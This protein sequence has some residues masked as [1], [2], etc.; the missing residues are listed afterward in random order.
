MRTPLIA[1]AG[2]AFSG[3]APA[4]PAGADGPADLFEALSARCGEA[5][6][7]EVVSADPRDADMAGERLVMHVRD[8]GEDV[9]RIPFHVG[10]DRSRTWVLTRLEDGR[11]RLKHDHRH[12][13]GSPDVLTQYGGETETALDGMRADFPAD[14][15][16][17]DLFRREGLQASVQNV[18]T[19]QIA[20]GAF[21]YALNRPDRSFQARFD[22]AAPVD[23]P[24]P[25]WGADG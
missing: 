19:V 2:L 18:W 15:E 12:E 20:D 9:L 25:P 11:M 14:A 13:D 5:Y 24:P 4:P 3:C 10:E 6:A 8:C 1:A 21:V 17:L 7:G 22:L 16:S 23:A